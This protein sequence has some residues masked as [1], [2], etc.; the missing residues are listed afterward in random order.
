LSVFLYSVIVLQEVSHGFPSRSL[1]IL[2]LQYVFRKR[3]STETFY[4]G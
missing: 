3:T 2:H 1:L 4:A